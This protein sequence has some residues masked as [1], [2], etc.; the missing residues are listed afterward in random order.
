MV[1]YDGD[2]VAETPLVKKLPQPLEDDTIIRFTA[3]VDE[4]ADDQ[5]SETI[6]RN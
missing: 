6:I 4:W 1:D 2:H 5:T 3:D